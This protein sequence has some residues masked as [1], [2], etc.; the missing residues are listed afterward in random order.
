MERLNCANVGG[1]GATFPAELDAYNDPESLQAKPKIVRNTGC[2][3]PHKPR[4]ER[5]ILTRRLSL[6]SH[7]FLNALQVFLNAL[8]AFLLAAKSEIVSNVCW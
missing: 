8:Q 6:T 2:V 1:D 5:C 3:D 4:A 7:A